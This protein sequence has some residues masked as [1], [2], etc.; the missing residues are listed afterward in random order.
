MAHDLEPFRVHGGMLGTI[1]PC[2]VH[3]SGGRSSGLMLYRILEAYDFDPPPEIAFMFAN[4]GRERDETLDF[5]AEM[6]TRWGARIVWIERDFTP[7]GPGY[8]IVSHNSAARH[9]MR[10][11]FDE[12]IEKRKMLPNVVTRFCTT[13][14]K[15]RAAMA[16]VRSLGWKLWAD[17][18]GYRADERHRLLSAQKRAASG[19]DAP[20]YTL[21]PMVDAEITRREVGT[22][23][24]GQPFDLGLDNVENKTP[25]GNCDGCFLK[26]AENL[27]GLYRNHPSRFGWW[28]GWEKSPI[29]DGSTFR[30]P[31]KTTTHTQIAEFLSRQGDLLELDAEPSGIDCFCT[32]D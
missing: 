13:E 1:D 19:K 25:D 21:A 10:S 11:P 28:A 3:I 5:V 7:D 22:F 18:L 26:S 30:N 31:R 12:L 15:I 20:R 23:W 8:R 24:A 16:Y 4:T 14:L 29:L 9:G 2:A 32:G 6:Q 27:G 17:V